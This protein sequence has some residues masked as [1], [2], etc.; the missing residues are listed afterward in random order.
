MRVVEL[1]VEKVVTGGDGLARGDDGK[2]V[3]VPGALPGELVRVE[4]TD[5]KRDFTRAR[6][7]EVL[8]P[9]PHRLEPPC[10][11]VAAG[12]G[13][14]GWQHVDL[15]EQRRLRRGIV[16]E[17]LA[18]LGGVIDADVAIAEPSNAV[19]FRTTVRLA[20][21]ADGR[22]AYRA[23][24]SHD[25]VR[26]DECLVAH[27]LVTSMLSARFPG[28]REVVLRVGARTGD[29]MAWPTGDDSGAR[30]RDGG[31]A[32]PQRAGAPIGLADD[33][34]VGPDAHV[35]EVVGGHRL[36]VGAGS[37]FQSSAEAAEA[38][39]RAVVDLGGDELAGARR[40]VDAYGGVGL[41]GALAVPSEA[42]L[43]SVEL[44]ASA[45][46]DARINLAGRDAVVIESSVE[47][48][49]APRAPF[50]VALADPSRTGLGADAVDALRATGAPT[51]VLVSCDAGAL[52]RDARL[53]V[54]RGYRF[55]RAQMVDAFPH[56]PH[57]E[58]VSRFEREHEREDNPEIE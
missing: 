20:V 2:V 54:E 46:A 17:A 44:S 16:V 58:V 26:V 42:H 50:D 23:A 4:V 28:A 33:V 21:D 40:V 14:C 49:R 12:C 27:P 37:F 57:V 30:R 25:L 52:G 3:F 18:R 22:T 9:S 24:R 45:C 47:R 51:V 34:R 19:G 35:E 6:V 7:T 5:A 38:I 29:R 8:E 11:F 43:T 36:R 1:R 41:L 10:P 53:L 32:R 15:D 39:A 31:I 56:T 48:W 13:G 55:G